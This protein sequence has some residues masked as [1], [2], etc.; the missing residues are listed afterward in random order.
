MFYYTSAR[1]KPEFETAAYELKD[2]FSVNFGTVDCSKEKEICASIESYPT[3]IFYKKNDYFDYT[4]GRQSKD[5]IYWIQKKLGK[6]CK[7]LLFSRGW[8]FLS[9]KRI[10]IAQPFEAKL[11]RGRLFFNH[12]YCYTFLSSFLE[13]SKR[14]SNHSL[15]SYI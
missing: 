11:S 9:I 4:G 2:D 7:D 12:E 6:K 8:K 10:R 14:I 5:I 13:R 15:C 3:L 1:L